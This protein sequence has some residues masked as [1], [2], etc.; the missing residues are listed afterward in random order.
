MSLLFSC[1][2]NDL[3]SKASSNLSSN[4]DDQTASET[5]SLLSFKFL[6][7]ANPSLTHDVTCTISGTAVTGVLPYAADLSSLVPT[8]SLNGG[9]LYADEEELLSGT[10]VHDFSQSSDYTLVS[11][12][13]DCAIYTV[14][15]DPSELGTEYDVTLT[16]V[17]SSNGALSFTWDNPNVTVD[18]TLKISDSGGSEIV[19]LPK[20]TS[21]Y[22]VGGLSNGS[23]YSY[24]IQVVDICSNSSEGVTLG[25][26]PEST[27]FS[28]TLIHNAEELCAV[29]TSGYYL[30]VADIDLSGYATWTPLCSSGFSGSY[31]GNGFSISNLTISGSSD[32][33]LGLFSKLSGGYLDRI[34]L[35]G[36]SITGSGAYYGA[37]WGRTDAYSYVTGCSV[38]SCLVGSSSTGDSYIGGMGGYFTGTASGCTVNSTTVRAETLGDSNYYGGMIGF[39]QDGEI[40]SSSVDSATSV[41]ST[42][43]NAVE[44]GGGLVGWAYDSTVGKSISSCTSRATVSMA[45]CGNMTGGLVGYAQI[46]IDN[47]TSSGSVEGY[48]LVGGLVGK[49][50]VLDSTISSCSSS[51]TVTANG[52]TSGAYTAGGLV[53]TNMNGTIMDCFATGSVAGDTAGGLVGKNYQTNAWVTRSFSTGSVSGDIAGGLIGLNTNAHVKES[54]AIC[55]VD[56]QDSGSSGEGGLIGVIEGDDSTVVDSYARCTINGPNGTGGGFVGSYNDS[57]SISTSYCVTAVNGTYSYYGGFCGYQSG[58]TFTNC[59]LDSTICSFGDVAN[60]DAS[61]IYG[62]IT[63]AMQPATAFS[64]WDDTIWYFEEGSYPVLQWEMD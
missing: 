38:E 54:F 49:L 48:Q 46:D 22:T 20:G 30:Q 63:S 32:D 28:Y 55:T 7:S 29:G 35:K 27:G 41:V 33:Y 2:Q 11:D 10:S 13:G 9:T 44:G 8:F 60:T 1:S 51:A 24:R 25:G 56:A 5:N 37:I 17:S 62:V 61:S 59:Y 42:A 43:S 3:Y 14:T 58:G 34:S 39:L 45:D 26:R 57:G 19:Q 16:G 47:C 12:A 36:A 6:K 53:G 31:D 15:L 40:E 52:T 18:Y 23:Y 64:G 50:D 21:S 4:P